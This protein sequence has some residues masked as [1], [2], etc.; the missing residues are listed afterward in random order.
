MQTLVQFCHQTLAQFLQQNPN[1]TTEQQSLTDFQLQ[2]QQGYEQDTD[3]LDE[4]SSADQAKCYEKQGFWWY[5]DA[6]IIPDSQNLRKQCLHE[7][8][9]CPYSGH[10]SITKTQKAMERLYWW[11]GMREDVRQHIRNC[12]ECQKNKTNSNKKPGGLPQPLQIPGRRWESISVDLIIQLPMTK[13]GSTKIVVFVD[14]L[15]KMVHFAAVST[16]FSAYDMARLY[17]RT[18]IRAHGVQRE[19]V[20][21][22]DTLFTSAFWEELTASLVYLA[23]Q[24][25]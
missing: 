6:L 12:S 7:L 22:R 21:D 20:S 15:S 5:G 19:I 10:L 17:L 14:R 2:V 4:L 16:V 11:K 23:F 25:H 8:H 1:L 13:S 18:I 3:W 24:I 9:H